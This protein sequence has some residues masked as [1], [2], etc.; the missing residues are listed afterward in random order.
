MP[1]AVLQPTWR[2]RL[3]AAHPHCRWVTPWTAGRRGWWAYPTH[4]ARCSRCCACYCYSLR[5]RLLTLS[6]H[7]RRPW[8]SPCWARQG[9]HCGAAALAHRWMTLPAALLPLSRTCCRHRPQPRPACRPPSQPKEIRLAYRRGARRRLRV[10][11]LRRHGRGYAHF[12]RSALQHETV[13]R[14]RSRTVATA[15]PPFARWL[16]RRLPLTHTRTL[17]PNDAWGERAAKGLC[18]CPARR[19][20]LPRA[21]R[22]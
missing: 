22:Q 7:W 9:C 8:P 4:S 16:G 21:H 11:P 13:A 1:T 12:L 10:Q 3:I 5:R 17:P 20:M 2:E 14:L 15:P 19:A 18:A 6:Y